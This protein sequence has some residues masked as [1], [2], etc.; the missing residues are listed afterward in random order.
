MSININDITN[1]D[2][3]IDIRDSINYKNN[4]YLNI[5]NIPKNIL[6][7]SPDIYLNKNEEYYL[8]CYSGIQSMFASKILNAL[9]YKCYSIDG[10][11]K[12]IK[13]I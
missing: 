1:I 11:L 10:G 7:A 2:N 8:M 12:S 3:I 6:L 4:H 5:R 9:G 13:N